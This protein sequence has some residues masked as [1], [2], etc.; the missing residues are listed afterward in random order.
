MGGGYLII[1]TT[2]HLKMGVQA[3]SEMSYMSNVPKKMNNIQITAV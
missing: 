1:M 2:S 3:A